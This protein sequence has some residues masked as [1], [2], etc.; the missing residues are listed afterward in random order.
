MSRN[1]VAFKKHLPKKHL[2]LLAALILFAFGVAPA[3]AFDPADYQALADAT[4]TATI[5][6]GAA[7]NAGNWQQYKQFIPVSLQWLYGGKYPWKVPQGDDYSI[8]IGPTVSIPVTHQF[9]IDTEKYSNQV[10]LDPM[11]N[12]GFDIEGYVAGLPFP[13]PAGPDAGIEILYNFY[14]H[15]QPHV[16]KNY[17]RSL[18]IDRYQNESATEIVEVFHRLM[19]VSDV[20]VPIN[21]PLAG[22][23]FQSG[24][25]EVTVPEQSKYTTALTLF[26]DDVKKLEE[27]YVFLPSLRRSLRLSS[28]AR[29]SPILG[30]DY[31]NDDNR[32]GFNGIPTQFKVELLGEKKIIAL[33][34][35]D[36]ITRQQRSSFTSKELP[37]WSKPVTGKWELRDAYLLDIR[38]LGSAATSYCYGSRV[39]YVDK[40]TSTPLF[41]D[42]Y[43]SSLKPWK[44]TVNRFGPIPVNDGFGGAAISPG[45]SNPTIYDIQNVHAGLVFQKQV[46]DA[47]SAVP[48]QYLDVQRYAT[49][50][51]LAQVMR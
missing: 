26:P 22:G 32:D 25:D 44:V 36:L 18:T 48:A 31:L 23:Y 20:N 17:Y 37:G 33:V 4:S 3:Q 11:P 46:A 34:H 41:V 1:I 2:P 29:C 7:I 24:I 27:F 50:G 9:A 5:A 16:L 14:Y 8:V 6:P 21:N 15:Y 28:A 45:D 49:P 10:K 42:L 43:D 51:G 13:H 19:H 12:G 35:E 39:L 38:A 30:S 47:N 40:E